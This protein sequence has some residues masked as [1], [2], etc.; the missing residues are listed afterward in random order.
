MNRRLGTIFT[1]TIPIAVLIGAGCRSGPVRREP[2]RAAT[3]GPDPRKVPRG[4]MVPPPFPGADLAHRDRN[5]TDDPG[6]RT[7]NRAQFASPDGS[8]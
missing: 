4:V 2:D 5:P 8:P 1:F 7:L 6:D 3:Q